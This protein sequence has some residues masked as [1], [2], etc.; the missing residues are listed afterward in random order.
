MSTKILIKENA[1]ASNER[2]ANAKKAYSNGRTILSMLE[3]LGLKMD[4]V[5]EW[6]PIEDYFRTDYPKAPLKF[7]LEANGIE[8]EYREVEA[9]YLKYRHAL[10]FEPVT[11]QEIEDIKEKSRIYTTND[12]QIEA[13]E[14]FHRIAA[15]LTCLKALKVHIEVGK[16]H[17][18][19]RVLAGH[20]SDNPPIQIN[21][22][23][24]A[25]TLMDLK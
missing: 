18:V 2:I 14:L 20:W 8:T 5:N 17:T 15:D 4:S 7:N 3:K 16:I 11:D 23:E 21:Q 24:L 1:A 25:D 19:T 22:R 13:Y 9:F 10:R 12:K 6:Q